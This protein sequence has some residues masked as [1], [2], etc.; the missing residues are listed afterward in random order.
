MFIS[1][2]SPLT[3]NNGSQVNLFQKINGIKPLR[4]RKHFHCGKDE[5]CIKLNFFCSHEPTTLHFFEIILF[6]GISKNIIVQNR[7]SAFDSPHYSDQSLLSCSINENGELEKFRHLMKFN[8]LT[9]FY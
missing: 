9:Y 7:V 1:S 3:K 4:A 8:A 2:I 5:K 6:C